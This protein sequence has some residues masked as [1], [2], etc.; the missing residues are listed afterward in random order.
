MRGKRSDG[1][2]MCCH[3]G[4]KR[5]TLLR[6][7]LCGVSR[8]QIA[9]CRCAYITST[10]LYICPKVEV[11]AFVGYREQYSGFV[12]GMF[13]ITHVPIWQHETVWGRN[14]YL[15]LLLVCLLQSFDCLW[16]IQLW[17][18]WFYGSC[19]I[20]VRWRL[21]LDEKPRQYLH[22]YSDLIFMLFGYMFWML[23][24]TCWE[25]TYCGFFE[26]KAFFVAKLVFIGSF[27]TKLK[28]QTKATW[29]YCNCNNN[30]CKQLREKRTK[31][32]R[33]KRSNVSSK[34]H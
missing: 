34:Q 3:L 26:N 25:W 6:I 27:A 18:E 4:I 21:W 20:C 24:F 14:W 16:W 19:C 28:S 5:C 31:N 10:V 17:N 8:S 15:K 23:L 1:L 32:Y 11:S 7:Q 12:G 2:E 22:F 13:I 29:K 33:K 30:L 9:R